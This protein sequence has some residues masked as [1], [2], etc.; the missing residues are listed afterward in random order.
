MGVKDKSE[1]WEAILDTDIK[2]AILIRHL[3]GWI[4]LNVQS[5]YLKVATSD[6]AT[7]HHD[8]M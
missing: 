8:T 2:G 5:S 1:Y 7:K 6:A 3:F 4:K